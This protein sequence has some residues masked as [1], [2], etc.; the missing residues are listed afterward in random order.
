MRDHIF[1]GTDR[2]R[3]GLESQQSERDIHWSASRSSLINER[4]IRNFGTSHPV[5]AMLN[6]AYAV[7]LTK[8]KIQAIA[9]GY[10]PMIGILHDQRH[11]E[12]DLT[13]SFAL[14]LMEPRLPVVDRVLLKLIAEETFSGAD[15][16]I[17]S[18]GVCRVNPE[19]AK[20]ISASAMTDLSLKVPS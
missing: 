1:Q 13:P 20:L 2:A 7:L 18:N 10:D 14:D 9:D 12:K 8:M 11:K 3:E 19:L 16:D 15:F 4:K 6:Y 17:Q 5:N